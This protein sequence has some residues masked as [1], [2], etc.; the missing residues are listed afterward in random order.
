MLVN[1]IVWQ[2]RS[3]HYDASSGTA[4][5][6]P[7]LGQSTIGQC[8]AGANYSELGVVGGGYALNPLFSVLTSTSGYDASNVSGDPG[9]LAAYCNGGRATASTPGPMAAMPALDEGGNAWIDVRFGPLAVRGDYHIGGTS[10]ALANAT[11]V[12]APARDFDNQSRPLAGI[13]RGADEIGLRGTVG[14]TASGATLS[15]T[16]LSFGNRS[17]PVSATVTFTVGGTGS[18]T[19]GTAAVTNVLGSAFSRGPDNCSGTTRAVGT[20]CSITINFA[21]PAGISPRAGVI[22]VP[23]NGASNPTARAL[24]GS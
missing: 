4:G 8:G 20:T 2:N 12:A 6:V 15:S 18:V 1:D 14:L 21:A 23:H 5:L 11:A 13:D 3:F 17:G 7:T 24:T 9:F 16:T 19:F 10:S 22:T